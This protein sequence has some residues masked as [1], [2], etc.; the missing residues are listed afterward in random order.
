MLQ[1]L[2]GEELFTLELLEKLEA[3][4]EIPDVADSRKADQIFAQLVVSWDAWGRGSS[5]AGPGKSL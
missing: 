1:R 4:S 2:V 3:F 5:F